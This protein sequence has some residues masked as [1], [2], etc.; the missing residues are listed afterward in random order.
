M[1]RPSSVVRPSVRLSVQFSKPYYSY[2]SVLIF[3]IL[4]HK[5]PQVGGSKNCTQGGATW[6]HYGT[7]GT[8][9]QNT[10][11]A[12]PPT[13]LDRFSNR[14]CQIIDCS[15]GHQDC[16]LLAA[17]LNFGDLVE[18]RISF[19]WLSGYQHENGARYG[20]GHYSMHIGT[21]IWPFIWYHDL[22]PQMTFRGQ[23]EVKHSV[24]VK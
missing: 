5:G 21:H 3:T 17:I 19:F 2:I 11:N 14:Q 23:T 15:R 13:I 22:W 12:T 9:R 10:K 4:A 16:T 18:Y 6:C 20:K 8:A 7:S 24:T 1:K